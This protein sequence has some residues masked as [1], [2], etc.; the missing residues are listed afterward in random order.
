MNEL[1][2][3]DSRLQSNHPTNIFGPSTLISTIAAVL[4]L[5]L[6]ELSSLCKAPRSLDHDLGLRPMVAS[7]EL[8]K[9]SKSKKIY[10]HRSWRCL[11]GAAA[12]F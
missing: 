10:M 7:W 11:K 5:P 12:G 6:I 9:N 3:P 2:S 1:D 4:L 8:L